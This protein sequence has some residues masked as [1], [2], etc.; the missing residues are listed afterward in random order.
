MADTGSN[1]QVYRPPAPVVSFDEMERMATAFAK[2]NLFGVKTTEQALSLLMIAQAEGIHPGLA[3][4]EYDIIEGKPARKAERL[5]ARFQMSGGKVEWL[6]YTDENVT[7]RFTH[8]QGAGVEVEWTI[9]KARKVR[10]FAR[11]QGGNGGEWKSLAEKYNWKNWPRAML[12]SRCISEGVRACF[13]G[14]ALVLLT[15]EEASDHAIDADFSP[16]EDDLDQRPTDERAP[17]MLKG[18][19]AAGAVDDVIA[20][21]DAAE[22]AEALEAVWTEAKRLKVSQNREFALSE[23]HAKNAAR[24]KS[25]KPARP[26]SPFEGL[27]RAGLDCLEGATQEAKELAFEAWAEAM[28]P[29]KLALCADAE[30][31]ELRTLYKSIKAEIDGP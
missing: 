13:P 1:L 29:E 23:A 9:E 21:M 27:K 26:P 17:A 31:D 30:R 5:L 19:K 20:R 22:T 24:I 8:P 10:Y 25:G 14:A 11:G 18:A 12:R 4:M 15:S 28:S 2:S 7:G 6:A 3:V 16:V